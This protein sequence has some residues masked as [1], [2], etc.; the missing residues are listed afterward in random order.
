MVTDR[1]EYIRLDVGYFDNPKV[2]EV[3]DDRPYAVLAHV[4]SMAYA[5][6]HRTD[7]VVPVKLI[8]RKV[9][10]SDDDVK[11][12]VALELWVDIG[13]GRIEVHDYAKHQETR[14][15]IEARS[16]AAKKANRVRWNA[17]RIP[18]GSEPDSGSETGS[19]PV[20][21]PEERRGEE[22]KG[23]GRPAPRARAE[24][25]DVT[26]TLEARGL[27]PK[28]HKA[29]LQSLRDHGI[30]RPPGFVMKAHHDDDG[31]LEARIQ[32]WRDDVEREAKAPRVLT[33]N[34]K[35]APRDESGRVVDPELCEHGG[36]KGACAICR[37]KGES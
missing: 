13:G 20:G 11:A 16:S 6:Q 23:A 29:F 15:V 31:S 1:R 33:S 2:A 30:T 7:G 14:E 10:A 24:R 17:H 35:P 9:G 27:P 25:L 32:E 18:I 22:R 12:L 21:N 34:T 19:P 37:R 26:G 8:M 5:R 36:V 28:D 4:A 3:L